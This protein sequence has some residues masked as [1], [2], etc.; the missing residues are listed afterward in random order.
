[1][2]CDDSKMKIFRLEAFLTLV[3]INLRN[4]HCLLF[5]DTFFRFEKFRR[6]KVRIVEN[7]KILYT[8]E[9]YSVAENELCRLPNTQHTS[10]NAN[11]K[12]RLTCI[13]TCILDV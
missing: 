7:D 2:S 8:R 6:P 13:C 12:F 4:V 5:A 9:V 1:M 3:E 10:F 11:L